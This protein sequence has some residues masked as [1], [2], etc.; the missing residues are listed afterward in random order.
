MPQEVF[1]HAYTEFQ[2]IEEVLVGKSYSP[3]VLDRAANSMSSTTKRLLTYLLD[4]TEEDYQNFINV[5]ET[6]GATVYRPKYP[7]TFLEETSRYLK[8]WDICL[9]NP[10]DHL[11]VL[12]NKIIISNGRKNL[13]KSFIVPLKKYAK[14]CRF[15]ARSTQL[16]CPS[17]IR[18]GKDIIIDNNKG[19]NTEQAYNY[20]KDLL[21]PKGYNI[22]YTKTHNFKFKAEGCHSDGVFAVLKPGV[23][24][25]LKPKYMYTDGIFPNWDTCSLV[26]ESWKKMGSW[27]HLKKLMVNKQINSSYCFNDKKYNDKE[28]YNYINTW[29]SHW[30]GYAKET[31]FD[32]NVF[33]LD[34]HHVCVSNYNKKAFNY[35]KKHKIEPIIIPW[36]HRYFWD[37]G[38]H[39]STLDIKRKGN[40]ESYL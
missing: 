32:V 22:I 40:V 15:D 18:L 33:S 31:V 28:F 37:G 12:D 6:Y 10:R 16:A 26:E 23:L 17:I 8:D 30:V 20:I 36:R 7:E 5:L 29:L 9:M 24:L 19:A 27:I 11:I 34:E 4:E 39:C 3:K 35:F 2:P 25:T 21:E 1:P 14:Y 38:L 13:V